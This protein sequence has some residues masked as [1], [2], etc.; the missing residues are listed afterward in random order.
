MKYFLINKNTK[1]AL[2]EYNT[3][4]NSI[5][6]VYEV[7]NIDFAPLYVKNASEDISKNLAKEINKWFRNR[8]IPAWRKDVKKYIENNKI[9]RN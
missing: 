9:K 4:Y 8:G 5:E 7:Y 3:I 6:K 1:V 2:L